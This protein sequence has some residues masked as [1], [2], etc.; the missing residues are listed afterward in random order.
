MYASS[1]PRNCI[2]KMPTGVELLGNKAYSFHFSKI[3]A[4]TRAPWNAFFYYP[5]C[6]M[7]KLF[8]NVLSNMYISHLDM[9]VYTLE[10]IHNIVHV[11][12]TYLT[13]PL[14][15]MQNSSYITCKAKPN[16]ASGP[17]IDTFSYVPT[18]S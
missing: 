14:Q 16:E 17:N 9:Y 15:G 7:T 1:M 2:D 8:N 3:N 11:R 13:S 12:C 10:P 18:S 4:Q 6:A 5:H